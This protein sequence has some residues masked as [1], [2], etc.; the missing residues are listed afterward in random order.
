MT[1]AALTFAERLHAGQQRRVDGA[2]FV[3]HPLEVACVLFS[4]GAPDHVIA[5]GALHDILEQTNAD[6]A[7]LR[8]RGLARRSRHSSSP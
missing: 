5:A 3:V 4:A 7:D 2:P 1:Q 8:A 6:S